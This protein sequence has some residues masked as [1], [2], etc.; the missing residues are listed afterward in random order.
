[1]S[2][3]EKFIFRG[4]RTRADGGCRHVCALSERPQPWAHTSRPK[5]VAHTCFSRSAAL[6]TE[7]NQ[8]ARIAHGRSDAEVGD[9]GLL[10]RYVHFGITT[11]S[12]CIDGGHNPT[13]VPAQSRPLLI[14]D[15][16][17]R[18]F[19]AFQVLLVAHVFVSGHQKLEA[20]RLRSRYQF[21]V[22]QPVPSSFD[23][24]K[25]CGKTRL[26]CHSEESRRRGTTR[27]LALPSK[28]SERDSSRS[29]P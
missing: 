14:A 13:N 24:F 28:H 22:K 8:G 5:Q 15:N 11:G 21:A 29:L 2:T 18:D 16:H 9:G 7:R 23:G 1:M 20:G 19:P 25:G 17:G 26:A 6:L 10:E 27:N 3:S 12:R 4:W